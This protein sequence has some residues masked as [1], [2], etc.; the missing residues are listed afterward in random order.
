MDDDDY[1]AEDIRRQLLRFSQPSFPEWYIPIDEAER[2]DLESNG[3]LVKIGRIVDGTISQSSANSLE[4]VLD[5][6]EKVEKK[7]SALGLLVLF[8]GQ[9]RD[10]YATDET[11]S[12]LPAAYRQGIVS[13]FAQTTDIELVQKM[14]IP[15]I[16]FLSQR[17]IDIGNLLRFSPIDETGFGILRIMERGPFT[18][19][20]PSDAIIGIL[21]HYGFPTYFIDVSKDPLVA[22]W[23]ALNKGL[24]VER[25]AVKMQ[26]LNEKCLP[27]KWEKPTDI[28]NW[29]TLHMYLYRDGD[30][31][32]P[33]VNLQSLEKFHNDAIR[34]KVQHAYVIPFKRCERAQP[35]KAIWTYD[36]D[37]KRWPHHIIKL[38]FGA[39]ELQ[40]VK[41][42]LNRQLLLPDDDPLYQELIKLKL[43]GVIKY[44]D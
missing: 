5:I 28:A 3:G 34:P 1:T 35:I 36:F 4:E 38:G 8:R 22:L 19:T 2:S 30:F 14:L 41:P 33:V 32:Y 31:E 42:N 24:T 26:P 39:S 15:W 13:P 20:Q 10:F 9:N 44:L 29:P 17:D 12:V 7:A 6:V 25:E 40:N 18:G 23:F 27:K 11:L 37:A 43:P 16:E 21:Q